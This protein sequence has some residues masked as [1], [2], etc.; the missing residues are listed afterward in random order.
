MVHNCDL[1]LNCVKVTQYLLVKDL[2]V[3]A[4][5]PLVEDDLGVKVVHGLEQLKV[6]CDGDY[7]G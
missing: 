7:A 6:R 1:R 2:D 4:E 5:H 3:D